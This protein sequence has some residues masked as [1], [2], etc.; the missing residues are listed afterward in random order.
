MV[1]HALENGFPVVFLPL[2]IVG[3][4]LV[5]LV[6]AHELELLHHLGHELGPDE[7]ERTLCYSVDVQLAAVAALDLTSF[8]VEED[9]EGVV[10]VDCLRSH[11]HDP[12]QDEEL[13][14]H[15]LLA[16]LPVLFGAPVVDVDPE[17]DCLVFGGG[18]HGVVHVVGWEELFLLVGEEDILEQVAAL[19]V[20]EEPF[21]GLG[22]D[23]AVGV[24]HALVFPEFG[25]GLAAEHPIFRQISNLL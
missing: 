8:C 6:L 11:P 3:R 18:V 16:L 4:E 1:L 5:G 7:V 14:D 10:A 19:G 13:A 21:A 2:E 15:P 22:A 9:E 17:G 23:Q 12:V 24:D 25:G 20:L